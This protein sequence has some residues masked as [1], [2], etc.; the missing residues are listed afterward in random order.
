MQM[1]PLQPRYASTKSVTVPTTRVVLNVADEVA[2][3]GR[4]ALQSRIFG[5]VQHRKQVEEGRQFTQAL[6]ER[7]RKTGEALQPEPC[8]H[9]LVREDDRGLHSGQSRIEQDHVDG[10]CRVSRSAPTF[11]G[12][13]LG[14]EA[15]H[16]AHRQRHVPEVEAV[17]AEHTSHVGEER[18]RVLIRLNRLMRH[19]R[20][21]SVGSR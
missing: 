7:G 9:K 3:L 20:G 6:F 17:A 10:A 13:P 19:E 12:V 5:L 8:M 18:R 21:T 14:A 16:D 11:D 4:F 1:A 15:V 2:Q